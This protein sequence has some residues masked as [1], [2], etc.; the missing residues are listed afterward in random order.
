MMTEINFDLNA[1][2]ANKG[3]TVLADIYRN[4]P[5]E[6]LTEAT[7][8]FLPTTQRLMQPEAQFRVYDQEGVCALG[9]TM[10][11]LSAQLP[12]LLAANEPVTAPASLDFNTLMTLFEETAALNIPLFASKQEKF[13]MWKVINDQRLVQGL[14]TYAAHPD[15]RQFHPAVS[16]AGQAVIVD[17]AQQ[18][19][20]QHVATLPAPTEDYA[21]ETRYQLQAPDGTTLTE[22]PGNRLSMVLFAINHGM[23]GEDV[24]RLLLRPALTARDA[25]LSELYFERYY[26]S[27]VLPVRHFEDWRTVVQDLPQRDAEH[28]VTKYQFRDVPVHRNLGEPLPADKLVHFLKQLDTPTPTLA[29]DRTGARQLSAQ[30]MTLA[31]QNGVTLQRHNRQN[32]AIA[33]AIDFQVEDGQITGCD[34]EDYDDTSTS[35]VETV[36]DIVDIKT[37]EP[38]FTDRTVYQLANDLLT[39]A[40]ALKSR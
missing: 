33:R 24:D 39:L 6:Q 34:Y 30:L 10:P 18:P 5:V 1:R 26:C 16:P 20:M 17:Q 29:N 31:A 13:E 14:T 25:A 2:L 38:Y 12:T 35:L 37:G 3:M 36:F 11:E 9:L 28:L 7:D 21:R 4:G 8:L 32:L 23:S 27:D 19:V 15:Q 22:I 40:A